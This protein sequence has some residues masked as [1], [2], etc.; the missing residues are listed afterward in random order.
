MIVKPEAVERVKAEWRTVRELGKGRIGNV[1]GVQLQC[2][3][4]SS[5]YDS[6]E[7]SVLLEGV[8]S[9]CKEIGIETLPEDEIAQMLKEWG[10]EEWAH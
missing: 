10:R 3:F 9:E 6:K 7:F 5:S 8:I 1:E 2:Y 4:G